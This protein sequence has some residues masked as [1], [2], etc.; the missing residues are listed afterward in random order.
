MMENEGERGE[1]VF[2]FLILSSVS[3]LDLLCHTVRCV[4]AESAVDSV[5][6]SSA[7]GSA[8]QRGDLGQKKTRA[9]MRTGQSS[10]KM[11]FMRQSHSPSSSANGAR[12]KISSAATLRLARPLSFRCLAVA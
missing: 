6:V 5:S 12:G 9:M 4:W 11:T 10:W 2:W 1:R 3:K 8:H 7:L